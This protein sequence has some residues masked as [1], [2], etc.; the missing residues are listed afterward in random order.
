MRSRIQ[1]ASSSSA[2]MH[3]NMSISV[4]PAPSS[5]SLSP[6]RGAPEGPASPSSTARGCG[7][8]AARSRRPS[9]G[10]PQSRRARIGKCRFASPAPRRPRWPPTTRPACPARACMRAH[11]VSHALFMY[12]MMYARASRVMRRRRLVM[13]NLMSGLYGMIALTVVSGAA[14]R[15]HTTRSAD[16][17][18]GRDGRLGELAVRGGKREV[19]RRQLVA[20]REGGGDRMR[21]DPVPGA[22]DSRISCTTY[23]L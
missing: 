9:R 7:A 12:F 19:E 17:R 6:P 11:T 21:T 5:S 22:Q 10:E 18:G 8:R 16:A 23:G 13:V 3:I 20:R 4:S 2:S 14:C 1:S 15:S